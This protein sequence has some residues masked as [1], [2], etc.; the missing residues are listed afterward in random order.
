MT[1]GGAGVEVDEHS[2]TIARYERG[3]SK[4]ETRGDLYGSLDTS[5]AT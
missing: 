5:A 3:L 4:F 1:Y 2:I